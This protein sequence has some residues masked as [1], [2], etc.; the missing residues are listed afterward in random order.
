MYGHQF[1][2]ENLKVSLVSRHFVILRPYNL[3][4]NFYL[5]KLVPCI[6]QKLILS[7]TS[8]FDVLPNFFYH[9]NQVVCMAALEVCQWHTV[10]SQS[11]IQSAVSVWSTLTLDLYFRCTCAELT[12]PMSWTASST[13]SCRTEHV[14]WTF[15]S[16][17]P[18]HIQ[19]GKTQ[20]LTQLHCKATAKNWPFLFYY[21]SHRTAR[22][23]LSLCKCIPSVTPHLN[24]LDLSP[25]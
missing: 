17:C 3:K 21:W 23:S 15:S 8:I 18:P 19:T 6:P 20:T 9:S 16:C 25:S 7:E 4:I 10:E 22:P 2:P 1:C 5:N 13:T 24:W 12:L 11:L 14:L